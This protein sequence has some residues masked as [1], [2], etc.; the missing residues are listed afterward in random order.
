MSLNNFQLGQ[1]EQNYDIL[2]FIINNG[3]INLSDVQNGVEAMKRTE[4]LEKHPYK[5]WQ[6]K[7]GEWYTKLVAEDGSKRLRH[8]KTKNELENVIIEHV[9]QIEDCPKIE[10]VFYE[11]MDPRLERGEIEKSTYSRYERDFFRY[12]TR[13]KDCKL[14]SV[15]ELEL[16]DFIKRTIQE[17]ALT[18]K[19]FSNMR[20]LIYGIFRYAKKRKLVNFSIKE[21]MDDIE[22]S[23]NEFQKIHHE[24]NEQ[25]FMLDEEAKMIEYLENNQD[26]IN[27]GL[28]LLFKTGLRIGEMTSLYKADVK[29]NLIHV[30]KTETI[31]RDKGGEMHYDIKDFPKTEAGIRDVIVPDNCKW[32]LDKIRRLCPFGQFVFMQDNNRIRSYVFRARLYANCKK[33]SIVVKSPHKVRKTYGSKLYDSKE[34]PESFMM[35]QMGHTDISCLKKHYYYNRMNEKEKCNILNQVKAL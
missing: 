29:E 33:L 11:W 10:T 15:T 19:A 22:F 9:K 5:I 14:Q 27:L 20:T 12:F 17:Q 3:M 24:D 6:G 21:V 18:R 30:S 16:E 34:I 31:Y 23:K 25:V 32:I 28:L 2:R 8:R 26:L 4:L 7:D 1:Q 35:E 13:I